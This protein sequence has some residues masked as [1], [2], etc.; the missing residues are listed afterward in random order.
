[1]TLT[2]TAPRAPYREGMALPDRARALET[3]AL[4]CAPPTC[5][6]RQRL[7][8]LHLERQVRALDAGGHRDIKG[9]LQAAL[10]LRG[11]HPTARHPAWRALYLDLI[12]HALEQGVP[13]A[14]LVALYHAAQ[15]NA[16]LH[17]QPRHHGD[18]L[19]RR[20][21]GALVFAPDLTPPVRAVTLN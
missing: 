17:G 9:A 3:L 2:R 14:E 11:A 18:L 19:V 12:R 5:T 7:D 10:T 1:M 16:D 8:L 13:G 21:G 4:L 15:V 20:D 6:A